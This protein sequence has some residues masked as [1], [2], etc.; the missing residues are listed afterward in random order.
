M[1]RPIKISDELYERL[2]TQAEDQGVALQDALVELLAKPHAA[3]AAFEQ[4]LNTVQSEA[5]DHSVRESHLQS[6]IEQLQKEV[7]A[8]SKRLTAFEETRNRD[9]EAHNAWVESWKQIH[10][11]AEDVEGLVSRVHHLERLTHRHTWQVVEDE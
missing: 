10:P 11:L 9:V 2:K 7:S 8:L 5:N 1:S 3:I 6:A 4:Q